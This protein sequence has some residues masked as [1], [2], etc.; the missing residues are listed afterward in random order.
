MAVFD[1]ERR[2]LS[3]RVVYDGPE[4]A[5][6]T[7]NLRQ[8]TGFTST[9][10]GELETPV[11]IQGRTAYFD[12]L[13]IEGGLVG[14]HPLDCQ[15]VTVPGQAAREPRRLHLLSSADVVVFV[16]DSTEAGLARAVPMM[17]LVRELLVARAA[18][19]PRLVIQANHQDRPG[20]R[21]PAEVAAALGVPPD[22]PAIGACAC[23]GTG[24]RETAVAAIR[25]AVDE[26][27][28]RVVAEGIG[29][30]AGA[31]Q[32]STALLDALLDPDLPRSLAAVFGEPPA[33]ESR[34]LTMRAP[35]PPS[36]KAPVTA[37]MV[38]STPTP[39]RRN[40]TP[41]FPIPAVRAPA[42]PREQLTVVAR[43]LVAAARPHND[44]VPPPASGVLA[45]VEDD[46]DAGPATRP[47]P[48][49]P[50]ADVPSG[51]IWPAIAGREILRA[52][53]F[54]DVRR[55]DDLVGRHGTDD[56]SGRS[57]AILLEAGGHFLKTS[58]RR[59]FADADEARAALVRLARQKSRLGELLPE[60]TV[61]A[62]C[63]APGGT[64]W[65]WTV[66]PWHAT[67]R[68]LMRRAI[69]HGDEVELGAALGR[70]ARAAV[71][72]AVLAARSRITLDV[73]PSNFA[74]RSAEL[75]Y[76]DDDID[77]GAELPA[78]GHALLRR[79]DE[80]ADHPVALAAYADA[81]ED[82]IRA[83]LGRSDVEV[84]GL[85]A[86]IRAAAPRSPE[87]RA[88]ADRLLAVIAALA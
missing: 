84:I 70:F 56:G 82:A 21:A 75:R 2:R 72:A 48:P 11:E 40:L 67:L 85:E 13:V 29:A 53:S 60:R 46:A 12:W 1:E 42:P 18:A 24:V 78:L 4:H 55:R 57:D 66:T 45:R 88:A 15:L 36:S 26:V 62:L 39:M 44:A 51:F 33:A 63:E 80:Y 52:V 49:L 22:V 73:S 64:Y 38:A 6:K 50:R 20:A 87:G 79:F 5:G 81:A 10:R 16:V 32:Q 3:V 8:L 68:A 76:L 7:T 61:L 65:L 23:E 47:T 27:R 74:W 31:A 54:D 71:Q 17:A 19:M 25:A 9:R 30:L 69:E 86:S 43:G 34:R 41:P 28:R 58:P 77:E 14:G 83:S 37:T 35:A 59:R